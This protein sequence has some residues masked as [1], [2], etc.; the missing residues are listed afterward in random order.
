[1][2]S[3]RTVMTNASPFFAVRA[4]PEPVWGLCHAIHLLRA[5]PFA[6]SRNNFG[7]KCLRARRTQTEVEEEFV[8]CRCACNRSRVNRLC[9]CLSQR[10]VQAA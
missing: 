7:A 10:M 3:L 2:E 4:L 8:I 9:G 1:M 6:V 5:C